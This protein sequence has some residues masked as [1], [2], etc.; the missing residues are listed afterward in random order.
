MLGYF[1][2]TFLMTPA[3]QDRS[4]QLLISFADRKGSQMTRIFMETL[5]TRPAA[6]EALI[7][8]ARQDA[9][10][11]V[12]ITAADSLEAPYRR[13]LTDAGIRVLVAADPP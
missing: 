2:E 11:A 13:A 12:A 3:E 7:E 5:D 9:V 4:R 10:P 6:I 8:K 1:L